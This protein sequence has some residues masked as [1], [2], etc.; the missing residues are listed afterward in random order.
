MSHIVRLLPGALFRLIDKGMPSAASAENMGTM[1]VMGI[2]WSLRLRWVRW[3]LCG[4]CRGLLEICVSC[5][6][7]WL[8]SFSAP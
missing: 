5:C 2:M 1:G 7:G 4:L 3:S 6:L 8:L